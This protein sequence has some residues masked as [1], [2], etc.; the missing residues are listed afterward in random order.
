MVLVVKLL[1]NLQNRFKEHATNIN[2]R[3]KGCIYKQVITCNRVQTL[4]EYRVG[5]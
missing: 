3:Q 1:L 4:I 2:S 5:R